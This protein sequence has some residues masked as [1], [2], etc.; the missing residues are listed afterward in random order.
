[1]EQNKL[2]KNETQDI[3]NA[4]LIFAKALGFILTDGEGIVVNISEN[5][6]MPEDIKKVIVFKFQEQ[7]HIYKCEQNLE[8]GTVVN[9]QANPSDENQESNNS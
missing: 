3:L 2:E 9:M 6:K 8:E 5:I 7:I 1:M 4:S